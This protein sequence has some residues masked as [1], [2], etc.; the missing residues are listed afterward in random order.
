[1]I[2]VDTNSIFDSQAKRLHAYKR[3]LLNIL[4]VIYLYQRMK[5]DPQFRIY[6]HTYIFAAKAAPAYLFAKKVIK[7]INCV[8]KKVNSD[9]DVNQMLRVVFLPNYSVTMSEILM[10]G[11]DVSE[12]ISTAGKEASGTGNMK[13]MMNGAITLGTLDGATVEID[14]LVGRE[15]DVIFGLQVEEIDSF[16]QRYRA[17]DYVNGDERIRKALNSLIDGTWN[18]NHDEFRPIY[19]ELMMKNDEY[20]V[21][22]DFDSYVKAQ[23]EISRRYEDRSAWAKS[24][25]INIGKS[26]Y[27]SSDRTIKQYGEE[28]W[29]IKPVKL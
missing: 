12:Q 19:E 7:L 5:S 22:A 21:L 23:E 13:F 18:G 26:A 20:L 2:E 9:P 15:N 4:H 14:Q 16:R 3:Q 6:P 27:F 24:C 1:G 11:S 8:A 29:G 17:I 25:L 28:I 10:N